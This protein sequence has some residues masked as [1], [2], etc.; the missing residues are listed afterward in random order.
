MM[1]EEDTFNATA[2]K[3][4]RCHR[5]HSP[6]IRSTKNIAS[7]ETGKPAMSELMSAF[8]FIALACECTPFCPHLHP[9]VQRPGSCFSHEDT[10]EPYALETNVDPRWGYERATVPPLCLASQVPSDI[11]SL[12]RNDKIGSAHLLRC[13]CAQL[14]L[15]QV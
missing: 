9:L 11:R 4:G 7:A 10:S 3:L 15:V 8:I 13:T 5:G 2:W 14:L 12:E 6:H 1:P